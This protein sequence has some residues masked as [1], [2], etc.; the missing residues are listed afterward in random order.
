[1]IQPRRLECQ[2]IIIVI[3]ILLLALAVPLGYH[4]YMGVRAMRRVSIEVRGLTLDQITDIGTR[5]SAGAIKRMFGSPQAYRT[6]DGVVEWQARS[7][8]GVMTFQ[9]TPL[10]DGA[11]YRVTS[12]A[13]SVTAGRAPGYANRE[14]FTGRAR[15]RTNWLCKVLGIP[16]NARQLLRRRRRALR[17]IAQA[18]QPIMA[19]S[20]QPTPSRE[21]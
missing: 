10:A 2:M 15:M 20:S 12:W 16:Q 8:G 13:S 1:L 14:T 17:A 18:G 7:S 9:V 21:L 5:A 6:P 11:S 19:P 4:R 3:L